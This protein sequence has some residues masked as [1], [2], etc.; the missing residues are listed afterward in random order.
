VNVVWNF[1]NETQL[2][3]L[4]CNLRWPGYAALCELTAGSSKELGLHS[5][6]V[7]A[8]CQ[9]Y[10]TRRRQSKK[11]KLRWRGQ[12]LLGWIPF[13]VGN[14]NASKLA[15]TRMAKSVLDAGWSTFRTL[16]HY[17]A[18]AH[19]VVFEVVDEVFSTRACS[20]CG[21]LS[22]PK[23]IADLGIR[24]W[25]CMECG[26]HHDRDVNSAKLILALGCQRLAG[27]IPAL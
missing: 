24:E 19:G 2:H 17:K 15:L 10:D 25:V 27:G 13:K 12:R 21:T 23:G 16:L 4:R 11:R 9:E 5:Q 26:S 14:V 8:V 20:E 7:Q 3:A 22:G 6:T 18:I 1:W